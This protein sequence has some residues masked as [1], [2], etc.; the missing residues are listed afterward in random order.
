M[1]ITI[2]SEDQQGRGEFDGGKITEQKPIAFPHEKSAVKRVGPLFYWAWGFSKTGGLISKHPHKAFEIMSYVINGN[3][4]HKDTI[5][6]QS[7]VGKGGVQVMQTGSG[8][9]HEEE[10]YGTDVEGF[11]IWFE[12]N[13]KESINMKP[14]YRQFEHEDFPIQLNKGTAV[15]TIIGENSPLKLFAD[16]KMFDIS[17]EKGKGYSH[18]IP[19]NYSIAALVIRGDGSLV[20]SK[21]GD[22]IKLAHKD[23]IVADANSDSEI[24]FESNEEGM[25]IVMIEVPTFVN[26]PLYQK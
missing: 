18:T 12:P 6:S 24:I 22:L 8:M 7:V 11:Q 3:I 14:T 1:N 21:T 25:R 9:E 2:F 10:S 20:E 16:A 23:F 4:A 13:R 15:K 5:G 26:Y 19:A 17:H